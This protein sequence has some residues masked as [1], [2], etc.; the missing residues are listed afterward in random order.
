MRV[1]LLAKT[2]LGFFRSALILR[3]K[4]EEYDNIDDVKKD[5]NKFLIYF[6]LK[7]WGFKKRIKRSKHIFLCSSK[8][9]SNEA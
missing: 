1:K 6:N 8:L 7:T 4:A 9:I 3:F 2:V 5:L